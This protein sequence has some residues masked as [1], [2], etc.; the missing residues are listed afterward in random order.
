MKNTVVISPKCTSES[1]NTL[2]IALNADYVNPYQTE[3]IDFKKYKTVIN[4]GFSKYILANKK[5]NST[6][7]INLAV[8]K[9]KT[10]EALAKS[11]ITVPYTKDIDVAKEWLKEDGQVVARELAQSSNGKGLSYVND[12]KT[13]ESIPAKFY[14]RL[15]PHSFEFRVNTWKDTVISIYHKERKEDPDTDQQQFKFVLYKGQEEHPQIKRIVTETY[16]NI[17]LDFSGIDVICDFNGNLHVLE[18]NSGPILFPYT[19][20]KLAALIKKEI[21]SEEA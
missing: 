4:Y 19:V 21:K 1:A 5:I 17:G 3:S 2:A 15:V 20:N 8:D 12:I 16:K 9:R 18:V 11:N 13:L 6:E 14:T 7:A 10:F